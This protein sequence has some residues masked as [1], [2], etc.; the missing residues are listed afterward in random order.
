MFYNGFT[1]EDRWSK[2]K[3]RRHESG[4]L[5][6][7]LR[8]GHGISRRT[9]IHILVAECFISPK[10]FP[11][12]CVRHRDGISDHNWVEN[13]RWGTYKQNEHDKK[14]HGTW[15][16]RCGG[17]RLT[18]QQVVKI[19]ERLDGGMSQQS[20]ANIYQVSRPTITRISNRSIWKS[21]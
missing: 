1:T 9:Y 19:R 10:P 18:A 21:L 3:L 12:A 7:D 6:I 17:S 4:Y 11:K 15:D 20:L 8:D 2:P 13:L 16:K 14:E 5:G